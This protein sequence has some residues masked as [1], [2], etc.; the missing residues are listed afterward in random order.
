M[1]AVV[2][3]SGSQYRVE[4]G[5]QIRVARMDAEAGEKVTLDR[6]LLVSEEGSTQIGTPRVENASVDASVLGHGKDKKVIVFKMKRRKGYR[7]KNGH[8]QPY[9]DLQIDTIAV[10]S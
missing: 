8:R 3:V 4:Q 1:Y 2:E 7:R 10:A 6:V 9:T 5:D